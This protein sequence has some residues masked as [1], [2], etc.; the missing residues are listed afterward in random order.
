[1]NVLSCIVRLKFCIVT[2]TPCHPMLALVYIC[3]PFPDSLPL[4]QPIPV[5]PPRSR[6]Y[7]YAPAAHGIMQ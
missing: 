5:P 4:P 6:L 7:G 3:S 2:C 1:M